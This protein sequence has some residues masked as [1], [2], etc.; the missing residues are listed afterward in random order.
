MSLRIRLALVFA[1]VAIVTAAAI[2]LVTPSIVERG[3]AQLRTDTEQATS[4]G[5][6]QRPG[7]GQ[8]AGP[9]E[10]RGPGRAQEDTILAIVLLGMAAAAGASVLGF[11]VAGRLVHPL[12]ALRDAASDVAAGHLERRSSVAARGD[13]IGDLARSFDAM[14]EELQRSDA[15]RRRMFQDAAHELRTPLAVI[16]ATTTAILDGVY[17]HDDRH[18]ATI[19]EQARA[20]GHIVADLRTVS[21]AEAGQLPLEPA[22][23][24]AAEIVRT[25]AVAFTPAAQLAGTQLR[26][27]LAAERLPVH[28]DRERLRQML[29]ALVDN[30]MRHV[31]PGGEI[32]LE[33]GLVPGA[34]E[35]AVRDDGPGIPDADLA[36]VFE[37]FYRA[38]PSRQRGS[39][40][41]GL[42]L[43]IVRALAEAQA[44]H[45]QA[46]NVEPHG[47]RF[48]IRL[49][50][51][52]VSGA[53]DD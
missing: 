17:E 22:D 27:R 14:A 3:F 30:A 49:P 8:G 18:L 48:R 36:H 11:L 25:V 35:L 12:R 33:G 44:G 19:R 7:Q 45:V 5:Q 51:S 24:D 13:E 9:R 42:G 29:A 31:G 34:V 46:Q 16:E 37:R 38:D 4:Q 50:R 32:V 6:G 52:G 43:S 26:V 28:A 41:S 21:L 53:P 40:T 10:G 1:L 23:L 20:L 15:V 47:A 2:A 39:G